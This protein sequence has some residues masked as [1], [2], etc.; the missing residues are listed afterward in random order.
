[1]FRRLA[2]DELVKW[3]SQKVR[4]PLIIRGARQVGKTTLVRQFAARYQQYIYL[5]LELAE[6]RQL[7]EEFS[8]VSALVQAIF[9]AKNQ[10]L[11]FKE[12]PFYL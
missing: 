11:E 3:S 5:N 8:D 12:K 9:F 4:K 1:M 10:L 2:I 7:F 6:D